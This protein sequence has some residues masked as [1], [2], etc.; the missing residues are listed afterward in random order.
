GDN[1]P[2]ASGTT[3]PGSTVTVTW[4]DGTTSEVTADGT[5]GEWTATAPGEQPDGDVT[6][7]VTDPAGNTGSGTGTWTSTDTTPP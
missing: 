4:P 7:A 1:I 3:E 2:T 6:A 5:T